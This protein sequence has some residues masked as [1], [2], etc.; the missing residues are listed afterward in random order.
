MDLRVFVD[1]DADLRVLRRLNRD[2][3]ERGRTLDSVIQQYLETVRP[4]HNEFVA[5]TKSTPT[6]SSRRRHEPS[7]DRHPHHEGRVRPEAGQPDQTAQ[8]S[9]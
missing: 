5:P 8:G 2:V 1:T 7:G 3:S 4:M 9:N 6:W